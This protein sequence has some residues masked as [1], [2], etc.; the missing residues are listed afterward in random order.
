MS[1]IEQTAP[2]GF[3]IFTSRELNGVLPGTPHPEYRQFLLWRCGVLLSP[4]ALKLHRF[5]LE[6]KDEAV[7]AVGK[8]RR[9]YG[10]KGDEQ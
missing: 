3:A 7:Q 4:R 2:C 5:F 10:D 9:I 1:N 6:P 8:E